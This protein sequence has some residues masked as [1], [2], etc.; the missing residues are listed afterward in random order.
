M[1]WST[2]AKITFNLGVTQPDVTCGMKYESVLSQLGA[3]QGTWDLPSFGARD[4]IAFHNPLALHGFGSLRDRIK[5]WGR[6]D[7]RGSGSG[8][9]IR[10]S[11][12]SRAPCSP[13]GWTLLRKSM[14]V[15]K[16]TWGRTSS[17]LLRHLG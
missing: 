1:C 16:G 3:R 13:L 6:E 5:V 2:A 9:G 12:G 17:A 14:A 11:R 7:P 10:C 4:A 8:W 15:W